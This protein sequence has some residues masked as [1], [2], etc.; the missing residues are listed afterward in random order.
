MKKIFIILAVAALGLVSSCKKSEFA[1]SYPDPTKISTTTVEKQFAGFMV[2]NQD[3]V[4][5]NY[6]NYF[7]VLRTTIEH[8][9]QATGWQ[10]G[11]AQYVPGAAS[12]G[13]IWGS[14]YNF[15]AQYRAFQSVYAAQPAAD[16]TSKRIFMIAATIYLYDHTEK[17]VDLH[18]DIPF[19]KAG[20][21]STNNGN[22]GDSYAAYDDAAGVYT[23][24]LDDLKAFAD[25]LN[26]ISVAS[27]VQVGFNNQDILN[28][29]SIAM[30]KKYCN[31]LR[32]RMLTRVSGVSTLS[33][34][35][36]SEIGSILT[37][38]TSYPI[39][40]TNADNIQINVYNQNTLN[41]QGFRSGLEDWNGNL[42]GKVMIEHM[43]TNADPRLRAVFEPGAN[44]V[45]G[46]YT[47]L[48]PM[49]DA[50]TQGTLINNGVIAF[51][52]RSTI[53]RNQFFPGLLM[54]A[55]EVQF[56]IAEY[57][58]NAGNMSSAITAYNAGISQSVKFYYAVRAISNDNTAPVLTP[59][60]DA[61]IATYV[62]KAGVVMTSG[63]AKAAALNLVGT[64]KW[65]HLNVIE[66]YENW[67]ELRRLKLPAL[68][69]LPDNSNT[70]TLPPSRWV[71]PTE[72]STYNAANYSKVAA[73][74]KSTT[75]I[76]WDVN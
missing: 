42:A 68:S 57:Y 16:Q 48:D 24:M 76:F 18:G 47:G 27:G 39:V 22:Y 21:L 43:K 65:L 70:L 35:A 45:G 54:T 40:A 15:L 10:N 61:E 69:F 37:N 72:E 11:G 2:A 29:G 56:Y 13:A 23:K 44:A 59:T 3:Y 30:W 62:A 63:L 71:Y 4:L 73:K 28:H 74:D 34:R 38:A 9:T 66:P 41:S 5:P 33:A 8:Y 64:Q 25:E 6:W 31:S 51:Y 1:A 7:V 60:S 14:Y 19:S 55:A 50:G 32:L 36:S 58:V 26:S 17:N 53:S 46:V 52:N 20:M 49:A 75:K 67:A 12:I